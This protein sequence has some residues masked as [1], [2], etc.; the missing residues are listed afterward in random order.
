[1]FEGLFSR[2]S[3]VIHHLTAPLAAERMRFLQSLTDRGAAASVVR[4][5]AFYCRWLVEELEHWPP[6]RLFTGDDISRLVTRWVH[7]EEGRPRPI[8]EIR[9]K[10]SFRSVARG[11]LAAIGRT[12]PPP[13]VRHT[14][15]PELIADFLSCE[16][17]RGL[18]PDTC[19]FRGRQARRLLV[20]LEARGTRVRDMTAED[21]DDYFRS[22][23]PSWCRVS[24]VSA[25]VA[26]RAWIRHADAR[27]WV[28]HGLAEA[29]LAPRVYRLESLPLGPPWES[30][31]EMIHRAGGDR[32][33]Q[34]RARA[35]LLLLAMYGLRSGEVRRLRLDD[36]DWRNGRLRVVR[37]KSGRTDEFP[38]HPVVGN[39]IARY[40]RRGRPRSPSRVI[41][42]T[43]CA[44]PRPLSMGALYSIVQHRL[45]GVTRPEKGPRGPHALRHACARHL[46]NAGLSLKMVGD[47]LGHRSFEA[48][49]IYTKVDLRSLRRVALEDLGGLA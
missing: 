13:E 17:E 39:A 43:L 7:R 21:L 6:G 33:S 36:L 47:H 49:R 38:L 23:A 26:I 40:L 28:R 48:T 16:Q 35:V 46:V 20:Y 27:G 41:F 2:P 4:R 22:L 10:D 18:S 15:H 12:A 9:P 19:D 1:M 37:S 14:P 34:L 31:A 8:R 3:A 32:P 42:L 45:L 5:A 30:V 24:L 11:F 29:I 25:A 44:P